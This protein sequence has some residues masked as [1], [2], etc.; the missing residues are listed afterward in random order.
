[1]WGVDTLILIFIIS[2]A[3]W[4]EELG[5]QFGRIAHAFDR[6]RKHGKSL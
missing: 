2:F 1:M 3:L 5:E 4:P 6:A